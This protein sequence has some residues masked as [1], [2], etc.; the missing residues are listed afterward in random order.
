MT[1]EL[2]MRS[3]PSAKR[4][5]TH[6]QSGVPVVH[7]PPSSPPSSLERGLQDLHENGGLKL[8]ID[9]LT[10]YRQNEQASED[11]RMGSFPE[12][13]DGA[14]CFDTGSE[15][16]G[17]R[18]T[19]RCE[20]TSAAYVH[21]LCMLRGQRP[22]WVEY[23]SAFGVSPLKLVFL[24]LSWYFQFWNSSRIL[25]EKN[26]ILDNSGCCTLYRYSSGSLRSDLGG[27]PLFFML[28]VSLFDH[29]FECYRQ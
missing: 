27:D 18:P 1:T 6:K 26:C 24:I 25:W 3:M 7:I 20:H 11:V 16:F 17:T 4:R 22:L 12:L 28:Y 29:W 10:I 5:K 2:S 23:Q 21:F 14:M 13:T 19:G 9:A 15:P 8:F